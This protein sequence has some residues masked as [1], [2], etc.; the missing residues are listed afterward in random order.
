MFYGCKN[1]FGS[2]SCSPASSMEAI[3]YSECKGSFTCAVLCALSAASYFWACVCVRFKCTFRSCTPDVTSTHHPLPLAALPAHS[4]N[5]SHFSAPPAC[6]WRGTVVRADGH[7]EA[8]RS[9]EA[10]VNTKARLWH[11]FPSL[12]FSV[13]QPSPPAT[14]S[15][16][17]PHQLRVHS[18]CLTGVYTSASSYLAF[19]SSLP[20]EKKQSS[21]GEGNEWWKQ[22]NE[23]LR[24]VIAA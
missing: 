7:T 6:Q 14:H 16:A 13:E 5:L 21:D 20:C 10:A 12:H 18:P 2:S 4:T 23:G 17:P 3:Q 22:E 8:P 11:C 19:S 9:A 24:N 15:P 1:H